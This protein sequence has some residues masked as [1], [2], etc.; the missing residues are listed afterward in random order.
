MSLKGI[1]IAIAL[2]S[3][4]TVPL[5]V[6]AAGPDDSQG[7]IELSPELLNLLREEMREIAS[8]IQGVALS[9]ATANWESIK[10]TSRDIRASYIME[11]K[12]TAAQAQELAQVLPEHFKKLDAGFHQRADKLG[13]AAVARDPELVAFQYSRLIES[14]A[15]CHATYARSRF[16]GFASPVQQSHH[17]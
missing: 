5:P 11:R 6:H 9:L 1:A 15:L 3:V 4:T 7:D 2:A 8:G 17:H 10:K 13:E 16:P 12:L 14:C